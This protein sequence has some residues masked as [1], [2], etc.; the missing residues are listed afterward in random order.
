MKRAVRQGRR[1]RECGTAAAKGALAQK[2]RARAGCA[3]EQ[4]ESAGN[5]GRIWTNLRVRASELSDRDADGR[6]GAGLKS[7]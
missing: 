6:A 2:T 7:R 3:G 4:T 5:A 1:A